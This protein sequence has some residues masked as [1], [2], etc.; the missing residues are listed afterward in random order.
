MTRR[1]REIVGVMNERDFRHLVALPPEPFRIVLEFHR[2]R[3][4]PVR[5]GRNRHEDRFCFRET[6]RDQGALDA[7]IL[8]QGTNQARRGSRFMRS[9]NSLLRPH[10]GGWS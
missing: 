5:R 7:P 4:I 1:K 8:S 9:L 10:I 2:G 6:S 3:R